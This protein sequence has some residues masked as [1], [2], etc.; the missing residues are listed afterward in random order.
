VDRLTPSELLDAILRET[1]YAYELRGSRRRQA[2]ENLKKLRAM[3]RRAQN[4]GTT[5]R[6]AHCRSSRAARGRRRV[7][8]GDRRD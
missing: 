1:A 7:E 6:C 4:R 8:R 5:R 2:R 3:I